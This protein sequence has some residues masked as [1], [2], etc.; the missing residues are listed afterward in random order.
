MTVNGLYHSGVHPSDHDTLL[1][2]VLLHSHRW[3]DEEGALECVRLLLK[4]AAKLDD[5]DPDGMTVVALTIARMPGWISVIQ[6]LLDNGAEWRRSAETLTVKANSRD[7]PWI[8]LS[9][10]GCGAFRDV[11]ASHRKSQN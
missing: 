4:Y 10:Y 7:C 5:L 1:R 11:F 3:D 2:I 6:E 9:P 8:C